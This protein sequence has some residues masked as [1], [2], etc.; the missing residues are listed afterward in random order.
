VPAEAEDFHAAGS[1]R[2]ALTEVAARFEV[3]SGSSVQAKFGASRLLLAPGQSAYAVIKASDVM[4]AV[5]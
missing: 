2:D 4:I 1:L 3:L 5:D